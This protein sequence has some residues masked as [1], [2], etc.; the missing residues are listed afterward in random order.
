MRSKYEDI[1]KETMKD[2]KLEVPQYLGY[3][4]TIYCVN[5]IL[6]R[7]MAGEENPTIMPMYHQCADYYNMVRS[8]MAV[9]A[10][11]VE[12]SIRFFRCRM[13]HLFSDSLVEKCTING[14]ITN[15]SFLYGLALAV[16]ERIKDLSESVKK[17]YPERVEKNKETY[18]LLTN[19][20][21]F[22]NSY[23]IIKTA[24]IMNRINIDENNEEEIIKFAKTL[25]GVKYVYSSEDLTPEDFL[26]Y[27]QK[28]LAIRF[29][30]REFDYTIR[31]A[32][33]MIE[34]LIKEKKYNG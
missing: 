25:P 17:N 2:N 16:K 23:D 28:V 12:R 22:V 31:E 15:A 33:E 27:G 7:A 18:F 1:I 11:R 8:T 30:T 19:G 24:K 13:A 32:K 29:C 10:S 14:V 3:G 5:Y 21:G 26:R 4:Y 34:D 9:T 20:N 6:E